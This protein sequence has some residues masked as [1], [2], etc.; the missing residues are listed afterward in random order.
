M[1]EVSKKM[2]FLKAACAV[3]FGLSLT[4][5]ACDHSSDDII[6]IPA[7]DDSS[8][9]TSSSSVTSSNDVSSSSAKANTY[10]LERYKTCDKAIDGR[11]LKYAY[12]DGEGLGAYKDAFF[13]CKDGEWL[14]AVEYEVP[15]D[16]D[17]F[18]VSSW[19]DDVC[20]ADH[21]NVID[22]VWTPQ[23]FSTPVYFYRRCEKGEWIYKNRSV[24][25]NTKGVAV[26]D[27]CRR[28]GIVDATKRRYGNKVEAEQQLRD[29]IYTYAGDG[30]W[31][32]FSCN[33]SLPEACSPTNDDLT[34]EKISKD[35]GSYTYSIY[36]KCMDV[37][38]GS[39]SGYTNVGGKTYTYSNPVHVNKWHDV[40]EGIYVPIED[41]LAAVNSFNPDEIRPCDKTLEIDGRVVKHEYKTAKVYSDYDVDLTDSISKYLYYEC[42][43]GKWSIF[44]EKTIDDDDEDEN[45]LDSASVIFFAELGE[46]HF[47]DFKKCNADNEKIVDSLPSPDSKLASYD[48]YRCEQGAWVQR[49]SSVTC[50]IEGV[51]VGDT[52]KRAA[53]AGSSLEEIY[54]YAGNGIWEES[55]GVHLAP[56]TKDCS[57]ENEDSYVTQIDTIVK[58]GAS[59]AYE[60][61][62]YHCESNEWKR[63]DC[64]APETACTDSTEGKEES[65]KGLLPLESRTQ[66]VNTMTCHFACKQG[67]WKRV[68]N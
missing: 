57:A 46:K 16:S 61:S 52:C 18:F 10:G 42:K 54:I 63:V 65:T 43:D 40:S 48:F 25:C 11:Y 51:S 22:S 20:D 55:K 17:V 49:G 39:E 30:K 36:C 50:N 13:K 62:Y 44:R 59:P 66:D 35:N 56:L 1:F 41:S 2:I 5:V 4:L 68:D 27:T 23:Q 34:Y 9:S 24:T 29:K 12:L 21:E 60:T 33:T 58:V 15:L 6:N 64:P 8:S 53:F 32:E 67:K 28:A 47:Y 7:D 31:E 45:V 3:A 38:V 19:K 26:G 14:P 37:I